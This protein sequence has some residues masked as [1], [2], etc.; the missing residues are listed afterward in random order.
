MLR[1]G[2]DALRFVFK[3]EVFGQD[4]SRSVRR[5]QYLLVEQ[6]IGTLFH[7]EFRHVFSYVKQLA[8]VDLPEVMGNDVKSFVPVAGETLICL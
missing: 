1:R 2:L 4:L 5:T 3:N 6:G 8:F 7:I